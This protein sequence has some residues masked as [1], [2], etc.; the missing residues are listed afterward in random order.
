MKLK[1]EMNEEVKSLMN[2]L[3]NCNTFE[4]IIGTRD[5]INYILDLKDIESFRRNFKVFLKNLLQFP[6]F[7]VTIFASADEGGV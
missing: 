1:E 4:T 5:D 3:E 2:K 7:S 6:L